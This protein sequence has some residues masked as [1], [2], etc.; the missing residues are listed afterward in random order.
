MKA[1]VYEKYGP[2]SE[3][4]ELK[5][6]EKPTPEDNELLIRNFA[7]SLNYGDIVAR[8][9]SKIPVRDF[10]MPLPLWL[11]GRMQSG[12]SKPKTTILGS[13]FAGEI[14]SVGKDVTRFRV[15]DQVF[16]YLRQTMGADAE[17]LCMPEDGIVAIKPTNMTYMDRTPRWIGI[18]K[19]GEE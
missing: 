6:V 3:V 4:L 10:H 18:P 12:F 2:P 17:Y 19:S 16:G 13:E 8:K 7:T 15:G 9:F 14:E 1:I 5:E 11:I